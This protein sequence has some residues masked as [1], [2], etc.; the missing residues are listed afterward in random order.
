[1]DMNSK[2]YEAMTQLAIKARE[3]QNR[4][5]DQMAALNDKEYNSITEMGNIKVKMYGDYRVISVNITPNYLATR[6]ADQISDGITKAF[7][8]CRNAIESEK[9]ELGKKYSEE[10]NQL[11]KE[12]MSP[13]TSDPTSGNIPGGDGQDGNV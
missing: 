9:D 11:M 3:L 7:N 12:V 2:D 10:S 4:L 8:N 5:R 6:T 13:K 1:M